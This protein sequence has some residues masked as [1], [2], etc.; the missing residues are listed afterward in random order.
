MFRYAQQND[1]YH[2][3][4][5]K[6]YRLSEYFD[7]NWGKYI[8]DENVQVSGAQYKAVSSIRVCRTATLGI[9]Y[10]ICKECGDVKEIYHN[11]RNRFCP[12]CSWGDTIKWASRINGQM[13][14]IPHRHVVFT[15]PHA[16]IPLIKSNGKELLNALLRTSADTF[17]DWMQHKY[18][19]KTGIISVLHTFGETKEY[20]VH[21]HMIVSWG[22]LD[23]TTNQMREI[24]G[25]YVNYEF[26]QDKFRNKFEDTLVELYDTE[27]LKHKF[28]DRL[29]M[30]RFLKRINKDRWAI[31]VEPPM[32]DPS[33]VIRYIGRYSKRACLSEYKITEIDGEY[34]SFRY[35]DYKVIGLDNKPVERILR[36]HYTEFFPRLLQ[37]VPLAYFRLVRYYGVY[38]TKSKIPKE[39]LNKETQ[40]QDEE[41]E[42]ENPFICNICNIPRQYLYTIIDKRTRENR[43]EKF[44]SMIHPS[45]IFKRA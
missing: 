21:V 37:H 42:W 29:S 44:D 13:M 15:L 4:D 34:I 10:Y 14:N 32:P 5:N 40:G 20:H 26:L 23:I 30:L 41:W 27:K 25:E 16:L 2:G 24:K 6:R 31:H 36:L 22:G 45:Y 19:V 11:C 33:A 7:A 8:S 3:H 43:I 1:P 39:Y 9:D 28:A 35:K 38:S 12:T 18:K 17:K